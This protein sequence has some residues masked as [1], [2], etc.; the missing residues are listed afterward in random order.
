MSV[1]LAG[2]RQ[3]LLLTKGAPESV[4]SR[5]NSTLANSGPPP[6]GSTGGDQRPGLGQI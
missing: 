6:T 5:C 3:Q 1:L 4:L 2:E